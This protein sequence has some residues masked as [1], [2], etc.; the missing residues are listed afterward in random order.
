M[1][2]FINYGIDLGTTN[3]TIAMCDTPGGEVRIFKNRD[4]MEVTPSV[5]RIE[6]SGRII[7][8]WRAYQTLFLDPE[9]VAAEFKRWMGKPEKKLFRASGRSMGAEELSAEVLKS[10]LSDARSQTKDPIK[11]AVIT[12]PAAFR[13]S[14]CEATAR[15]AA[16]AGLEESPLLQEPI[17][18]S[19]AYG[20]KP[21]MRGGRWLVYDLG[22][23]TFDVAVVS[24][25]DARLQVLAHR[26]DNEL[27]GKN[28]D[29]L[30]IERLLL[31]ALEEEYYLPSKSGNPEAFNKLWQVL[32]S[33]SEELKKDLSF[34]EKG[35]ARIYD[36]GEDL[37]GNPIEFEMEV[38][39]KDFEDLIEPYVVKTINLCR[40]VIEEARLTPDDIAR[41]ILVGGSTY[42]P[43]VREALAAEFGG[44]LDYSIDPVTVVARGAAI[45]A[46]MLPRQKRER[47]VDTDLTDRTLR[48]KLSHPAVST[49]L[50]CVVAGKCEELAGKQGW[51]VLVEGEGNYWNSGW[52]PLV[53]GFFETNVLLIE[54]KSVRFY[55]RLRDK[56]G[57]LFAATPN[58]F[59]ITHNPFE[60][61]DPPL[62]YSLGVEVVEPD[63]RTK[64]DVIAKRSTPI[65]PGG[66]VYR[67][68]Y[69]ADRSLLPSKP[70]GYIAIKIWE[71]ENFEDPETSEF[72]GALVIWAKDLS[73]PLPE[74][75]E[76]ELWVKIDQSRLIYASAHVPR[77]DIHLEKIYRCD[78]QP[79]ELD[80]KVQKAASE[81]DELYTELEELE[82]L[83]EESNHRELKA[84][85]RSIREKLDE[86]W[87]RSQEL[88]QG[89][90]SS[91]DPQESAQR[92][93][94][95]IRE[96]KQEIADL[97]RRTLI[98]D[99]EAWSGSDR[100]QEIYERVGK[101]VADYGTDSDRQE[102]ELFSRDLARV[103]KEKDQRLY[104]ILVEDLERFEWRILFRQDWFWLGLLEEF[105]QPG[106]QFLD[107]QKAAQLLRKG[108]RAA[109]IN[110]I[111][112][113]REVVRALYKLLPQPD[114]EK[115][116]EKVLK[117]G[118]RKTKHK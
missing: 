22:G 18:A 114:A 38:S 96:I 65:P 43:L 36:A 61:A 6:K 60:I 103:R 53:D 24:S 5:V 73:R 34:A 59:V 37:E 84:S 10:L 20:M 11:A 82:T 69:Y 108:N 17:A 33:A 70:D 99:K 116:W 92:F 58:S 21:E 46:S 75:E 16:L 112:Q 79:G 94:K 41:V 40:K 12:V 39:R 31:P 4:Q 45:Y 83:G 91:L 109:D 111:D 68:K 14:Q 93:L 23:G 72:A 97:R 101:L 86:A 8:G 1:S 106:H 30:I 62:P 29:I 85:V 100:L 54:G 74:G 107:Q 15:A 42:V 89:Q 110:D 102:Y 117:A 2:D 118:I 13:H 50:S 80:Q 3:S 95:E 81:M 48:I 77:L 56:K 98:P 25:R 87:A 26:G 71:G 90:I 28:F 44:E 104:E 115:D 27:G 7:V 78:P 51:E 35:V 67:L 88:E 32:K 113:V 76:I 9:N 57:N 55:I 19:I 63:G 66:L 52:V 47:P 49:E 105:N 64:V